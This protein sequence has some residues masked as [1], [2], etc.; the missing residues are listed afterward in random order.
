M[1]PVGD[2][3]ARDGRSLVDPDVYLLQTRHI[4]HIIPLIDN[5]DTGVVRLWINAPTDYRSD[6][7]T[8]KETVHQIR[9]KMDEKAEWMDLF[10]NCLDEIENEVAYRPG[11]YKMEL[12]H[13]DFMS[14]VQTMDR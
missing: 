1:W 6:Y 8:L 9:Q 11:N 14:H 10:R 5:P 3:I 4:H 2:F 12:A 7:V 13:V